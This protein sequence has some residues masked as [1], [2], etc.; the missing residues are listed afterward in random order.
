MA[1][2]LSGHVGVDRAVVGESHIAGAEI[3]RPLNRVVADQDR[4]RA[5]AVDV[6]AVLPVRAGQVNGPCAAKRDRTVDDQVRS[7]ASSLDVDSSG[8]GDGSGQVQ[9]GVVLRVDG[10]AVGQAG[11]VAKAAVVQKDLAG[12]G[13]GQRSARN[14]GAV[15]QL[16]RG[17]GRSADGSTRVGQGDAVQLQGAAAG[18]FHRLGVGAGSQA[19]RFPAPGR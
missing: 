5:F 13:R 8:V 11:E 2:V 16:N 9:L 4:S 14:R 19:H 17:S 3:S 10:A 6:I 1:N 12:A 15:D 7:V 18:G